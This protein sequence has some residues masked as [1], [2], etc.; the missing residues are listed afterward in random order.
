MFGVGGVFYGAWIA[1]SPLAAVPQAAISF[2]LAGGTIAAVIS[3]GLQGADAMGLPLSGIRQTAI[4]LT[5]LQT[6]YGA[7]AV[8]AIAAFA[9]ASIGRRGASPGQW[10]ATAA[11]AAAGA[12][13]AVSGHAAS[14]EPQWLTRPA[15]FLHGVSVAFWAGAFIPLV[16]AL[17]SPERRAF[18]LA[19]FSKAIPV[20]LVLL[21]VTGTALS[22]LQLGAVEALWRT[23][24]GFILSAK[25][26]VVALLLMLGALNRYAFTPPAVAGNAAAALQMRMSV[27][28]E[29]LI[30]VLI[31]GLVAA[32][33]FTPPPRM[34]QLVAAAPVQVHIHTDKAMAD[35]RFEPVHAGTRS[36]A[37]ALW[38]GNFAPLAAKEVTLQLASPDAGIEPLR[39]PAVWAGESSWRVDNVAIPLHGRWRI[40]I[41]ILIDDFTKI[42]VTEDAELGH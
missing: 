36:V 3:V 39:I 37:I 5:G 14:A 30:V 27:K 38:D 13:L 33:R 23:S 18:E 28:A 20:A 35:L 34:L 15:V 26:A 41:E 32:W 42:T 9:F 10:R 16:G 7:T 21:I 12:A 2:S 40:T 22:I 31:F 17:A 1:R 25:L 24:Y 6:S 4:W 8:I 19:R 11:M 29:L